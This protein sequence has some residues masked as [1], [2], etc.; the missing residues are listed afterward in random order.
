MKFTTQRTECL[1]KM[2]IIRLRNTL[3]LQLW[4]VICITCD[5]TKE[6]FERGLGGGNFQK[7]FLHF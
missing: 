5:E 3:G 6:S 2:R 1:T 4:C 7:H